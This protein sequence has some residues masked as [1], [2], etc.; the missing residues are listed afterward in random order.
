[1]Q[2]IQNSCNPVFIEIG[3][4]LGVER[5]C[6]YFRQFGLLGATGVDLPGEAVTIM[7]KE[8]STPLASVVVSIVPLT[9]FRYSSYF[10]SSPTIP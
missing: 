1:M 4:R 2:G 7:H 5:F 6:D 10:T 3:L 8:S 9:P